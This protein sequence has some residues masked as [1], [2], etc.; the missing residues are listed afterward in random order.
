MR[1]TKIQERLAEYTNEAITDEVF[2]FQNFSEVS[3]SPEKAT[4]I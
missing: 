2:T 1:F 3:K 4:S